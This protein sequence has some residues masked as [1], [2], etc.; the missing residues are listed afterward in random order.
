MLSSAVNL[1]MFAGGDDVDDFDAWKKKMMMSLVLPCSFYT[2]PAL[3]VLELG[4]K[5]MHSRWNKVVTG[6][7]S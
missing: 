1:V 7:S 5:P 3:Q 4:R 6:T 2:G